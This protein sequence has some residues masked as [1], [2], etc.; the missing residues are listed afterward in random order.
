[1]TYPFSGV[2]MFDIQLKL[3][4]TTVKRRMCV[5]YGY[6]PQWHFFDPMTGTEKAEPQ[7]LHLDLEVLA[8]PRTESMPSLKPNHH[9]PYWTS[10]NQLLR[11]GVLNG[12]VYERLDS[13]ID[14]DARV[15]DLERRQQAHPT[16]P[17]LPNSL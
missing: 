4:G 7:E 16:G 13:L 2:V 9:E 5:T 10:A 1:M 17:Q 15:Q 3:L 12:R 11:Y 6:T 8:K 14:A